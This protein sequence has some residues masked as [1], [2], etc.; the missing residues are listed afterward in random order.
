MSGAHFHVI[1]THGIFWLVMLGS[2]LLGWALWRKSGSIRTTAL[3]LIVAGSLLS[4]PVYLT[5]QVADETVQAYG[6]DHDEIHEH[7]EAAELLF[8]FLLLLGAASIGALV[9]NK[10]STST[11]VKPS[12]V[13]LLLALAVTVMTAR[14]ATLGGDVRHEEIRSGAV[15][16]P[17]GAATPSSHD[18]GGEDND[19]DD[20]GHSHE[21]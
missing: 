3:V 16:P 9:L 6:V 15:P 5:G 8:I 7:A 4:I 20:D 10:R 13:V 14:V 2:I 1:F 18:H 11:G 19:D 21:H 12:A 17:G